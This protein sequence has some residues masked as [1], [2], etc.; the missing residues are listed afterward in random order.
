MV[1]WYSKHMKATKDKDGK[2]TWNHEDENPAPLFSG[3]KT[4]KVEEKPGRMEKMIEKG[5]KLSQEE[6]PEG[7]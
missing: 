5:K 6:E 2:I 1:L 7:L 3:P 4:E